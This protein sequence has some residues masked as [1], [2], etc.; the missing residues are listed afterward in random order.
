MMTCEIE[1][2]LFYLT[3]AYKGKYVLENEEN[4]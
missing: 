1:I 3:G 2:I 4:T